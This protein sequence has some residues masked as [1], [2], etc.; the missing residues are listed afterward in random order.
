MRGRSLLLTALLVGHCALSA[1][2]APEAKPLPSSDVVKTK[3]SVAPPHAAASNKPMVVA[4]PPAASSAPAPVAS[5]APPPVETANAGDGTIWTDAPSELEGPRKSPVATIQTVDAKITSGLPV[6]VVTRIVRQQHGRYRKCFGD[7]RKADAKVGGGKLSFEFMI[8]KGGATSGLKESGSTLKNEK[9]STCVSEVMKALTFPAPEDNKPAKVDVGLAF[10]PMHAT[11]NGKDV[12]EATVD[13]VKAA[14]KDAGWTD[15]TATPPK[16]AATPIVITAKNG[17]RKL[18]LTFVPAKRGEKDPTVADDAKKKLLDTG[19]VFDDGA[20]VAVVVE[21]ASGADRKAA[22]E[23]LS[24][25][26]KAEAVK[27][28]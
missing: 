4:P 6:E 23:L 10:E 15:I 26:L 11:V 13:D 8:E 28:G 22:S 16:D 14:L 7:A 9:L 24:K 5:A 19:A 2:C 25:I 3:N 21:G 17:D 27:P 1:G 12:A 20:F 18:T